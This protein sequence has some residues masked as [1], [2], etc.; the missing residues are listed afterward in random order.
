MNC[1]IAKLSED[2]KNFAN[3]MPTLGW[4]MWEDLQRCI[5]FCFT[6][7]KFTLPLYSHYIVT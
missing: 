1:K 7:I 3:K 5:F 2:K 4:E 6:K